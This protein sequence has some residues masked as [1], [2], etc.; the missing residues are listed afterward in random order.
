[1][2]EG[3]WEG[4]ERPGAESGVSMSDSGVVVEDSGLGLLVLGSGRPVTRPRPG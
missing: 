4:V 1:M 2:A 3:G